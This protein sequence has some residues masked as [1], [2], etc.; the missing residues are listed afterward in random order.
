MKKYFYLL[1]ILHIMTIKNSCSQSHTNHLINE[2]SP[3]LLQHAHNPV[4]WYPYGQAA[5]DKAQ[6]ENKLML[7]SIGYAACHWCHVMEHESFEDEDIAKVMN[8]HFVCVKVDREE[9]PDIDQV[10]MNAVQMITGSG[11]W[12][13]NC[14]ALPDGRPVWGGTYFRP[15]QWE[16]ILKELADG[17]RDNP[18]KFEMAAEELTR[19]ISQTEIIQYKSESELLSEG[20]ITEKIERLKIDFDY[21]NGGFLGSPKFPMP[22]IYETLL[23]Y[24]IINEDK[25]IL[26]HIEFTLE[27]WAYSGLYDILGGGFSRYSVDKYWL[28]PHF[29]KMLYDNAQMLSL[30]SKMHRVNPKPVFKRIIDE[31]VAW[32]E[33]DMLDKSGLFYSSYDADSEGEEGK[34]YI[35]DKTEIE[36]I[37]GD[38]SEEFIQYYGV[39]KYGNFERKN[40]L[41]VKSM[42]EPSVE[43]MAQKEKLFKHREKRIKP[44]LDNKMLNSWNALTIT[45]LCEAY[46]TTQNQSYLELAKNTGNAIIKNHI[47]SDGALL[48]IAKKENSVA[49]FLDDYSFSI[50]AFLDLYEVNLDNKWLNK[51]ISLWQKA[52]ELFADEQSQMYFY[53]SKSSDIIVRKMELSDN[54]IPASNAVMADNLARLSEYIGKRELMAKAKQMN[55]NMQ[56]SVL[57]SPTYAYE[58]LRQQVKFQYPKKELVIVGK[59]AVSAILEIHKNY[60][61]FVTIT[62]STKPNDN[63]PIFKGRWR[64]DKTLFYLCINNAC[65]IP[66]NDINIIR[67]DL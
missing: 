34:F 8:K 40:I 56:E 59:D 49:A 22:G 63:N 44:N 28:V 19:G 52:E 1:A 65:S 35:W 38:K 57:S 12:P 16:G 24:A 3:Y 37:L 51:A 9:R 13:L 11:G 33:R 60:Y 46:L 27:K 39:T 47:V 64:D 55:K 58:W 20:E 62:G 54:V 18:K 15:K 5:F 4:N 7:F 48:R 6:K 36:S 29:E 50:R 14:F 30:Y 25:S 66:I 41:T 61:P 21:E 67:K 26:N 17:Y 42:Q 10:Y 45:G 53:T 31:T 43:I 23:D 2:T 32:L